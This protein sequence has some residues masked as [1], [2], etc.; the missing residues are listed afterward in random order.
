MS[1]FVLAGQSFLVIMGS[2]GFI[3]MYTLPE[4]KMV[5][6]ED[7]VDAADAFGQRNFIVTSHGLFLHSRSPSEFSRGSLSSQAKMDFNFSIPSK[8][9]SEVLP[10]SIP[11]N[12][13]EVT[14]VS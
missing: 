5:C 3:S 6:K 2:D 4:L 11:I 12:T 7:C 1:I 9:T 13:N 10:L 14:M 8:Y